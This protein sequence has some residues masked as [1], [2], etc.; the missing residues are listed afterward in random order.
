MQIAAPTPSISGQ[1]VLGGAQESAFLARPQVVLTLL[2]P[3]PLFEN[4]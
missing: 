4:Y 3:G 2:V 1:V